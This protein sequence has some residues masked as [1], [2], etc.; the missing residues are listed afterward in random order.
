MTGFQVTPGLGV[1]P[2]DLHYHASEDEV[3]SVLKCRLPKPCVWALS[4]A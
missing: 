4:S 1:I 2:P 3:A